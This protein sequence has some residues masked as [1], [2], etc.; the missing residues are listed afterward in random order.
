MSFKF[1]LI[2]WAWVLNF[3]YWNEIIN[4]NLDYFV[5]N[6]VK[7]HFIDIEGVAINNQYYLLTNYQMSRLAITYTINPKIDFFKAILDNIMMVD[8]D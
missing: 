7:I 8:Y 5:K 4:L 2:N 1:S 6:L 3:K